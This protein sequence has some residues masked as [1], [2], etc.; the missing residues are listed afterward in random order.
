MNAVVFTL[1]RIHNLWVVLVQMTRKDSSDE[2]RKP[3]LALWTHSSEGTQSGKGGLIIGWG[4][5]DGGV[6]FMRVSRSLISKRI[7]WSQLLF[8]SDNVE[9]LW[10]PFC[11][12]MIFISVLL[13]KS[14][15]TSWTITNTLEWSVYKLWPISEWRVWNFFAF[16]K[17]KL[18]TDTENEDLLVLAWTRFILKTTQNW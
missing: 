1:S 18:K 16:S 4:W 3:A 15:R 12:V 9:L 14:N 13:P 6:R 17:S 11:V 2:I 5:V 7:N 8:C 10:L